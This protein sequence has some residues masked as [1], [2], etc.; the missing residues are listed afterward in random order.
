MRTAQF[1]RWLVSDAG[2]EV[3]DNGMGSLGGGVARDDW[4]DF[5]ESVGRKQ[6]H[7]RKCL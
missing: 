3:S 1:N 7:H 5:G 4:D 2:H 6:G